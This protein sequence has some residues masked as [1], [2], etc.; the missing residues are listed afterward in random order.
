MFVSGK[1]DYVLREKPFSGIIAACG[2]ICNML[3]TLQKNPV[4]DRFFQGI[5]EE[6]LEQFG[7]ESAD[8]IRF[9][10]NL[11]RILK[12]DSTIC[13]DDDDED[14]VDYYNT[15]SPNVSMDI[16][17]KFMNAFR[18]FIKIVCTIQ[19]VVLTLDDLQWA[20]SSS[21]EMLESVIHDHTNG[22]LMLIGTYRSNE[23][24]YSDRLSQMIRSLRDESNQELHRVDVTE[25]SLNDLDVTA[26][27]NILRDLLD[28]TIPAIP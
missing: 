4:M 23:V 8:I 17:H 24:T 25:I 26:V 28:A 14:Q 10:P 13:D 19:P 9:F 18:V 11:K 27:D 20:D 12:V 21:L 22:D 15:C 2:D 1:F 3:L 6:L 5:R 16:K 7:T